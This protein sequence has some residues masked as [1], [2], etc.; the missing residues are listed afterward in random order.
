MR[1]EIEIL[2]PT[3]PGAEVP[4]IPLAYVENLQG[5]VVGFAGVEW[6]SQKIIWNRLQELLVTR[7]KV[8]DVLKA[9]IPAG[10][11]ADAGLLDEMAKGCNAIVVGP[12]NGGASTIWCT[13]DAAEI[14]RRGTPVILLVMESF[15]AQAQTIA[16]SRGFAA[17]RYV[18]LPSNIDHL[19]PGDM[20]AVADAAFTEILSLLAQPTGNAK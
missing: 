12:V 16:R 9:Q 14:E 6:P 11:A 19:L 17:M 20:I 1:G 8:A 7:C 10:R 2:D 18:A 3:S 13:Y 5:K 4:P 15:V